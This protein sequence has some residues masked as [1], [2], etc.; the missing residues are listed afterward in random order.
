MRR[1]GFDRDLE[2][3]H[4]VLICNLVDVNP[5]MPSRPESVTS[6]YALGMRTDFTVR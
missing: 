3:G 2:P 4:Y 1:S 5:G 6:Y